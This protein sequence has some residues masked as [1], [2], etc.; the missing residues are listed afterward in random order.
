LFSSCYS[1]CDP[2]SH[3]GMGASDNFRITYN[4]GRPRPWYNAGCCSQGRPRYELP[5]WEDEARIKFI[6]TV[7]HDFRQ[8]MVYPNVWGVFRKLGLGFECDMRSESYP[9]LF[10]E[11]ELRGSVGSRLLW[12]SN[13]PLEQLSS[14]GRSAWFGRIDRPE[15]MKQWHAASPYG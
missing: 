7:Y 8:T 1:W 2:S 12:S 3:R 10:D 6:T 9:L 15:Q 5:F 14:R 11:P 13:F 4:S